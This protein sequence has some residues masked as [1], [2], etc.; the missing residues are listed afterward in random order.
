M[1]ILENYGL[2]DIYIEEAKK[3]SNFKLARVIA[4]YKGL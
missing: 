1:N 2:K 3:Y 4:Q